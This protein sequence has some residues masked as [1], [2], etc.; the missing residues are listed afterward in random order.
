MNLGK[1]LG[2]K[3]N[4]NNIKTIIAN[5]ELCTFL[6]EVIEKCNPIIAANLLTG[7]ILSY[8]NTHRDA[9]NREI[10]ANYLDSLNSSYSI[11]KCF[12]FSRYLA[13][14]MEGQNFKLCEGSLNAFN[15]GDF[16]HSWIEKGDYVYDV[17]FMGVWP[18]D[19]YY[20]L[21]MPSIEK[22]INLNADEAY[23]D[24]KKNTVE[25]EKKKAKPLNIL[26]PPLSRNYI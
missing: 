8:L 20:K 11:G 22:V 4:Q 26:S 17:T 21:F 18:K 6:E 23:Q 16:P 1:L 13:L 15:N 24:Y 3:E 9:T 19:V 10:E 25:S 14:S 7:D 12:R 2:K 5:R